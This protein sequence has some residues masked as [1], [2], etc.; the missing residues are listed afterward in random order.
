MLS[1]RP[2]QS[3]ERARSAGTSICGDSHGGFAARVPPRITCEAD[4]H[5]LPAGTS[6]HT[7][8][9]LRATGGGRRRS[10]GDAEPSGRPCLIL[11]TPFCLN[12][13]CRVAHSARCHVCPR[14]SV[15]TTTPAYIS[16]SCP[17]RPPA[18]PHSTCWPPVGCSRVYYAGRVCLPCFRSSCSRSEAQRTRR[19]HLSGTRGLG[20][21]RRS[22]GRLRSRLNL[23]L[24][25]VGL[26]V[27]C[28]SENQ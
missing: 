4:F 23:V 2:L 17:I 14:L 6:L 24:A 20:H 7:G 12:P 10:P 22:R 28:R 5:A 13:T 15:S 16:D 11:G 25:L 21:G 19:T 27:S 8:W 18:S 1:D 26:A 3:T 9:Q